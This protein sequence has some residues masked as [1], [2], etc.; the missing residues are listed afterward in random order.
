MSAHFEV[1]VKETYVVKTP[2]PLFLS[3][4]NLDEWVEV[5][6]SMS[7]I[8]GIQPIHLENGKVIQPLAP[9]RE[10]AAMGMSVSDE[11]VRSKINRIWTEVRSRGYDLE[12]IHH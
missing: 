12:N 4:W 1:E 2:T 8:P 3:A 7:D 6:N 9:G 11:R 5:V 10:L